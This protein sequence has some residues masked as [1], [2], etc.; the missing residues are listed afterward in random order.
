MDRGRNN[1]FS[2]IIERYNH[3]KIWVD[4]E[5]QTVEQPGEITIA[6]TA[7][8]LAQRYGKL[9]TEIMAADAENLRIAIIA[10]TVKRE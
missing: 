2:R 8:A 10:G 7:D 4:E 1:P 3:L 5:G 9:P 6:L